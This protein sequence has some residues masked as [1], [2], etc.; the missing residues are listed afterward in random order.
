MKKKLHILI[1]A[2]DDTGPIKGAIALCNALLALYPDE[3]NILLI[4]L[5]GTTKCQ[6]LIS[7]KVQILDVSTKGGILGK[8]SYLKSLFKEAGTNA[9][10]LSF[11][12]SADFA[13]FLIRA[14]QVRI[15][16]VRGNLK[17]NYFYTYGWKG[18]LLAWF[19]HRFLRSFNRVLA[20]SNTLKE[21]LENSHHLKNVLLVGNFI[22]ELAL[23]KE[24][25]QS[26]APDI[27]ETR[28]VFVGSLTRRKRPDLLIHTCIRLLNDGEIITVKLLGSGPMQ[29]ELET[30]ISTSGYSDKIKLVGHK[31]NPY[32]DIQNAD[33]FILPS[34]SEGIPRAALEAMFFGVSCILRNID[35]NF[36]LIDNNQKNGLLFGTDEDL[37]P[38][39]RQA[40]K[41]KVKRSNQNL[42]PEKFRMT[43]NTNKV[44]EIINNL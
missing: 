40:I 35:A 41:M 15:S 24:L 31:S 8:I 1:P 9:I 5:K 32:P 28:L 16:S 38:T 29:S 43:N 36:E 39:L 17:E 14:N 30:L 21:L 20:L 4:T 34:E 13:N 26:P 42:I 27:K 44:R 19:H 7:E 18:K 12:F 22:D 2:L 23:Q 11:C 37:Y 25:I 33:V 10:V 3:Y 6:V